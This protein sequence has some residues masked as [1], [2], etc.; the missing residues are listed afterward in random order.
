MTTNLRLMLNEIVFFYTEIVINT[1]PTDAKALIILLIGLR[2]TRALSLLW[3][4][5]IFPQKKHLREWKKLEFYFDDVWCLERK[6]FNDDE[7]II[8][9][10]SLSLITYCGPPHEIFLPTWF[11]FIK[12]FFLYY[13]KLGDISGHTIFFWH[14]DAQW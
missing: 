3:R 13:D 9:L 8:G 6:K 12:D 14:C 4:L 2:A 7:K 11:Y 5:E 1:D 10:T